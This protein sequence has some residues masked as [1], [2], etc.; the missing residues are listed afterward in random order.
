MSTFAPTESGF[1]WDEEPDVPCNNLWYLAHHVG[2]V[3]GRVGR[4]GR[5]RVNASGN[6]GDT[7]T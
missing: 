4:T 3:L 5:T 6:K 7:D 2:K 1:V